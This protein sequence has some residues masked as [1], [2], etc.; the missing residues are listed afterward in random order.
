MYAKKALSL[1][2]AKQIA[3]AAEAEA[4]KNQW[5]VTIA[6][7]DDGGN[8][9]FLQ[10]LDEAPLGS[11]VVAQEKA[12]TALLFKRPTKAFEEII[13]GGRVAML[14]LPGA[15]P[16]EGGLPL[17]NDGRIVGSIGVSGV[18]S[19]QDAQIAQAGVE[20]AAKL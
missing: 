11:I 4:L 13:A 20:A 1:A 16:I 15:T 2:D 6:V 18:Q 12:R 14:T 9:L 3:A 8:L 7:L 19:P 17:L 10:R 5:S